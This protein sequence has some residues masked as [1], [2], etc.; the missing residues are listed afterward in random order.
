M[1]KNALLLKSLY[2]VTLINVVSHSTLWF[3]NL[4]WMQLFQCPVVYFHCVL[5]TIRK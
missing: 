2:P 5:E 1:L 4:Y 3:C